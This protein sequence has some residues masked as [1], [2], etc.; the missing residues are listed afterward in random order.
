MVNKVRTLDFLPE[1]FKTDTNRQFLRG[2][3]DVLT[4]QPDLKRI[5]G[6]IGEKYG[7]SI[8]PQDRYI[9]EPTKVRRDYQL[10]PS[11]IFLKPETQTAQDFIDYPGMVQ[12]LKNQGALTKKHDRLWESQFY[13]WEPFV[14]LDK[15]VN[16]SQYYWIPN[17]P[18]AV[19]ISTAQ[20]YLTDDYLVTQNDNGY[21][22]E[23]VLGVNPTITLIRGGTYTFTVDGTNPFWI[24]G[25]PGLTGYAPGSNI[26]TRD[27]LGVTNNGA[28]V[29]TVTFTVPAQDAQQALYTLPGNNTVDLATS[30]TYAQVN[31]QPLSTLNN[32]DG[33]TSLSGKSLLFFDNGEPT[34]QITY[35]TI[36]ISGGLIALIPGATIPNN[37]KITVQSGDQY[38]GR[39]FYRDLTGAVNLVPYNS[40]ILDKL[41]YQS[42]ND[43]L[44]VGTINIVD[45]NASNTLDIDQIIGKQ[46][47]I[48]PNGITFTNGLKVIF[49]GN[50][51]PATYTNNEYYVEGVGTSINLLPV[52]EYLAVESTGEAIYNPYSLAP[53]D[54]TVYDIDLY[55]PVVPEYITI[56]RNS[57]DRN[58]WTR[59]N[60]WFHQ[61]VL[62][63]TTDALGYVTDSQGNTVTRALRPIV[64]F[65]GNLRLF[66]NGTQFAGFVDLVA[67]NSITDAFSQIA[68]QTFAS[69]P[70]VD[71]QQ[72]IDQTRI[73]FPYDTDP[74]VRGKIYQVNY[75]QIGASQVITLDPIA[76]IE[77]LELVVVINGTVNAGTTWWFTSIGNLWQRSQEKAQLNQPPLF[78]V[79]NSSG[80]SLGDNSVYP[81]TDFV[82][83]KLFSYTVGTGQNDPVLGF[84]IVYS[85]PSTLG[86]IQF[87]VNLNSDTFS[88]SSMSGTLTENVNTGFVHEYASRLDYVER[89]GWVPAIAN[90]F[91]YQVFEFPITQAVQ[92]TFVCDVPVKQDSAWSTIQVYYNDNVLDQTQFSHTTDLT[93]LTTSVTLNVP[94]YEKEKVTVLLISDY[95]SKTAYYEIPNNLENNPFNTNITSVTVGD[96]RNQ[97]R[98]I[99][100]NNP[101]CTGPL[102]GDNN[103]H[104]LGN[105]NRYGTAIIQ[106][107]A[108]L[109]LPAT[110]L[111]KPGLEFFNALQF[112]S[113]QYTLYKQLVIDLAGKGD[114]SVYQV[115]SEIL[116]NILYQITKV[117]DNSSAFFWSDML[118][119]GSPYVSNTYDFGAATNTA[120]FNLSDVWSPTMF[121]EANY[122]GV[123]VYVNSTQGNRKTYT[124]LIHGLDYTVSATNATVT[125]NYPIAQ[126]DTVTVDEYNQTY[127]SYCPN[128]P[129]KMGMY[130]AW[131]PA[132]VYDTSYTNPTYFIL[133]HDGSYNKLFGE[134]DP[135]TGLLNDFR[136]IALLEFEKRIFN[137]IKGDAPLTLQYDDVVPG[138]FRT[139]QYTWEEILQIYSINFLNWVG[140]NRIDFRQQFYNKTNKF[141]YNY[142]ETSDKLTNTALKQGYWRG[143]Y[144]WFY[145]T[146]APNTTPWQM[147]G[148][149]NEPDWW[150][151]RYGPAPYTGDNLFM[152]QDIARGYVWND[153]APY[154]NE[155]RVRP[156][157]LQVI[158]VD[159][160]GDLL[161]PFECVVSLYNSL[162]F[163]RNWVVG[164]GAPAEASYVKSSTWPF[165][166][167]RLLALTKPARFFN[168]FVDQDQYKFEPE[169]DQYLYQGRYHLD[170]RTLQV[171]GSGTAKNSYLNWIVDYVNQ[172]G[173][174]GH[175][176]VVSALT[177]LDVRLTYNLAGFSAKDYLRFLV[178]TATPNSRNTNLLIPDESYQVLLYDNVPEQQITYSS[179]IVQKTSNGWTVYGNSQNRQY[180]IVQNTY[181]TGYYRDLTVGD[182]TVQVNQEFRPD[183]TSV[184]P[185]GTLFYSVQAV[186]EFLLAYGKYL[187]TQ[188][189]KFNN[190]VN[191]TEYNW[192]RMAQEYIVWAQ[193]GWE[194][195]STIS[196]NPNSKVFTVDQPGLVVQPLTV[197]QENFILNQSFLPLGG[198]NISVVRDNTAFAVQI[199]TPGDTV[200]YT[201]L[202]LASIEHAI[203]FDNY[204]AFNDTI[205]N[206]VTG[207]RQQRLLLQGYKTAEWQG[208]VNTSGFILN[209][210]NIKEWVPNKKYPKGVIVTYK[211]FYWT[212][213][214]LIEPTAEFS[215]ESWIKTEYDQIKTGLLPNP[216]T[217]AY[218]S[219]Y[220]YDVN[221]ANLE[222]DADLLS[223]SLIGFR[224]RQYLADADL[225]DTTQVNVYRNIVKN[226]GTNRIAN[227]FQDAELVQGKIDYKIQEN[228]ALKNGD[229]GAVLNS[230]FVEFVLD[231]SQLKGNP[232]LIGFTT[233]GQTDANVQQ[234]VDIRDFTN[235]ERPVLTPVFLPP[236]AQGYT[237][238]SG[239]PTAGYVN[240]KDAKFAEFIFEDLNVNE[241]NIQTLYRNDIVWLANYQSRWEVFAPV[242]LGVSVVGVVNNFNN[243]LQ[244][245]FSG[246]H[247]LA[248]DDLIAL[249][250]VD[251]D[252][253][254][255]YRVLS[256]VDNF[257]I[258]IAGTLTLTQQVQTTSGVAF[259][260][261]SRRFEQA[262]DAA[263]NLLPYSAWST[264]KI[265]VDYD[266]DREWAVYASSPMFHQ[267]NVIDQLTDSQAGQSVAYTQTLGVLSLD[268]QGG[269]YRNALRQTVPGGSGNSQI[270][271]LNNIVFISDPAAGKIY[272]YVADTNGQFSSYANTLSIANTGQFAVSNDTNWLY[273]SNTSAGKISLFILNQG[274]YT[275]VQEISAPVAALGWGSSIATSTDGR[276]LFVGAPLEHSQG[277]YQA[278]AAYSYARYYQRFYCNGL[279]QTFALQTPATVALACVYVD[280]VLQTTGY[281]FN[282]TTVTFGTA[283]R[284]G[285]IVTVDTGNIQSVQRFQSDRLHQ[286]GLYGTSVDTNRYGGDAVV[287]C[288]YEVSTVNGTPGV[289]GAVYRYTNSGQMYGTVSGKLSAS[290]ASGSFF[291]DG[292]LVNFSGTVSNIV[293][294]INQQTP[295]NIQ[296]AVVPTVTDGFVISVTPETSDTRFN[297][298]DVTGTA[299][300]LQTLG[301]TVCTKTQVITSPDLAPDGHFGMRV[302][303]NERSGLLVSAPAG[304]RPSPAT[305][306]LTA[307]CVQD[308]TIFDHDATFFI[309][310]F[311]NTGLVYEF[312]YLPA[313]NESILN[314]G[315][316][317]FGQYIDSDIT[318]D[319]AP[320]AQFGTS[321]AW[322]NGVIVVGAPRYFADNRG[323]VA[324]YVTNVDNYCE[325]QQPTSWYVDKKPLPQVNIN[326]LKNICIY[327][328]VD[329]QTLEW[330][331]YIDPIQNKL[332]GAVTENLDIM[333]LTDPAGYGANEIS[334]TQDYVG[335]TWLDLNTI[336]LVDYHQPDIVYNANNW[337][338]AFPG[339]TAD[340][341]TWVE[342]DVDPTQ[343]P[344]PGFAVT[345][346]R[347][348]SVNSYDAST[349]SIRTKY[350]FWA[351]YY[352]QVPAGKSLSAVALSQYLLDPQ[353]TGIAYLAPITNNTVAL[354][355]SSQYIQSDYSSLHLGFQTQPGMDDKHTSWQLIRQGNPEDFLSGFYI[356]RD[357]ESQYLKFIESFTGYDQAGQK[358]P[359]PRLPEL[360]R[361]GT[362]FRPRQSMFIDRSQALQNYVTYANDVM[363]QYPIAQSRNLNFLQKSGPGYDTRN[364]WSY[365]NWW[366]P[367]YSDDT[368]PVLEVPNVGDLQTLVDEQLVVGTEGLTLLLEDGLVVKVTNN[369]LGNSEYYVYNSETGW[370]QIGITNGTIQISDSIWQNIYGWSSNIWDNQGW[371]NFPATEIYWIIRWL[372]EYCY[373]NDLEIHR[374]SS[375]ILMFEYIQTE[376]LQGQNYLPWLNKTSLIDVNHHVRDLLPYKKFQR[377]NQEFLA[378]YLNEI[379][380]YHVY[381]K[382]F[383]FS[384]SGQ[385]V[386]PGDVTD[387]D[388]P[389]QYD[390][391]SGSFQTPR[392]V[393]AETYQN[394]EYLPTDLIW[395]QPEYNQWFNNYGLS[396]RNQ[397]LSLR[398]VTTLTG[399]MTATS[400]SVQVQSAYG[401]PFT[402]VITIGDEILTYNSI[403][404]V[405]NTL[406]GILRGAD[407]T[408][409]AIH[410]PGAPVL[411]R[412]PAVTVLDQGRLYSEPPQIT[413]TIDLAIYPAPREIA[414]FR[415][416]MALDRLIG[417]EVVNPGSG[418]AVRPEIYITPSVSV[419]FTDSDV[420]NIDNT[421]YMADHVYQTGD[422]VKFSCVSPAVAPAGMRNGSYYYV[423]SI[424]ANNIALFLNY[425]ECVQ[426][427]E[428]SNQDGRIQLITTGSGSMNLDITA[429]AV[430]L[431]SG[432][433]VREFSINMRYD[434]VS[435]RSSIQDWE[436]GEFY[437]G[438][439]TSASV[440]SITD[441]ASSSE[442]SSLGGVELP[443]TAY[444][445]DE[446]GNVLV[447]VTYSNAAPGQ[448]D[449][450]KFTFYQDTGS[451]W[452]DPASFYVKVVS[453]D[454]LA[455]YHDA[456]LKFPVSLAQYPTASNVAY[457]P[458][459]FFFTRSLVMY[460]GKLWRCVV[461][462]NDSSFDIDKWILVRS[463]DSQLTA[464][465]RVLAFYKPTASMPGRDLRQLMLGTE[466]PDAT[467]RGAPFGQEQEPYGLI[468]WSTIGWDGD[469]DID[470]FLDTKLISPDFTY[471]PDTNPTYW[472]VQ[473]GAFAQGYG[474]E[475]L[476]PGLTTDNLAFQVTT[477]PGSNWASYPFSPYTFD[478]TGFDVHTLYATPD[479]V[480]YTI[481]FAD[482]VQNPVTL[483]IFAAT[484]SVGSNPTDQ[485][486]VPPTDSYYT[487]DWFNKVITIVNPYLKT[488]EL[489]IVLY[490]FGNGNQMV[491]GNAGAYA[492]RT[493][494]GH[495]EIYLPVKYADVT[496]PIQAN[497]YSTASV[498]I[499]GV[500][501]PY[502]DQVPGA[503]AYFTLEPQIN[504]VCARLVFN[505]AYD[506][507]TDYVTFVINGGPSGYSVPQTQIIIPGST[508]EIAPNTYALEYYI[509]DENIDHVIVERDGYRLYNIIPNATVAYKVPGVSGYSIPIPSVYIPTFNDAQLSVDLAGAGVPSVSYAVNYDPGTLSASGLDGEW[510]SLYGYLD[511]GVELDTQTLYVVFDPAFI[512]PVAA[513]TEIEIVYSVSSVSN[514]YTIS[515]NSGLGVWQIEFASSLPLGDTIA[516]TSFNKTDQQSLVT[517]VFNDA[518]VT[519]ITNVNLEDGYDM[520]DYDEVSYSGGLYILTT[521]NPH[522]L[523]DGDHITIDSLDGTVALNAYAK[524]INTTTFS[525]WADF[526]L[527]TPYSGTISYSGSGAFVW[528][529]E[530]FVLTQPNYTLTDTTRLWVTIDNKLGGPG[531]I[532]QSS[533]VLRLYNSIAVTSGTGTTT[534]RNVMGILRE[535]NIDN[536]TVALSMV[537]AETPG[538]LSFRIDIGKYQTSKVYRTNQYTRTWLTETTISTGRIDDVLHVADARRLV[539]VIE[540]VH[541]PDADDTFRVMVGSANKVTGLKIVDSAS[542]VITDYT[543]DAPVIAGTDQIFSNNQS[544]LITINESYTGSVTVTVAIGNLIYVQGE[545]VGFTSIDL[546]NNTVTGLQRA[547]QGT[548]T[549][550]VFDQYSTVQSV[551]AQDMMRPEWYD[552]TWYDQ[553]A[554][555]QLNTS[556]PALF[557]QQQV[558]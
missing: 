184:I 157:L 135:D 177:N 235:W 307:N 419:S 352:D 61:D 424:D 126:G 41:Y 506:P 274:T 388:L 150:V 26:N 115:P 146:D 356:G 554:P 403:N 395:Q 291:V 43:P 488:L 350:Y 145:D 420:N 129:S 57:R 113:E 480:T 85:N 497:Y 35:Y 212:S 408:T 189:V 102:Y 239:I 394:D 40:S 399:Y 310:Q 327:N 347:F 128:T 5:Q 508:P 414:T 478:H 16:Y 534:Y 538:E 52:D 97:Y 32:I 66:D 31:G 456:L 501:I 200:A 99:F 243:T 342:S 73:I 402:G 549:N 25:V 48:S 294:Q 485:I 242:S 448:I 453:E 75:V 265:W 524:V 36:T 540:E 552:S 171:Y 213:L 288:P 477:K 247:N 359:D 283:P 236:Y 553:N 530:S 3:L 548:I 324:K 149:A 513:G 525:L 438:I 58:A 63:T 119:S 225:S 116:D 427:V 279:T 117:R 386:Y 203:V 393:Y 174:N 437:A 179:V 67:D 153:G 28:T 318:D 95:A 449:G 316:Y 110:F 396:I 51:T 470:T 114:Y 68:G 248:Q 320:Q 374:N 299:A 518:I 223:Y 463:D 23:S 173:E 490:E 244:V 238:E 182:V 268:G 90:S 64:E 232:T 297:L 33:I 398:Q 520:V 484:G 12:A 91:Q 522:G 503:T 2:T 106:N 154:I 373:T 287:G 187:E 11:V 349:N 313:N 351:K 413:A 531:G 109:V 444:T 1:I 405:T 69:A 191:G 276:K 379:K 205:Y 445:A 521:L 443:V 519:E 487:V 363:I 147:L 162:T 425:Q 556:T 341:Y 502:R 132:V 56:S 233:G 204:T 392:L 423:K 121:T 471:D 343:Y 455:L 22:F 253:N 151:T 499:N 515:Y 30:L 180:F 328:R 152:W 372:N 261:V 214:R 216:S 125:I 231:Q 306:D 163:Q 472:D 489:T 60:R 319:V 429:R 199:L 234:S 230:N 208:Y 267:Q 275:L 266:T 273:V 378:G 13:S 369:N 229:F 277:V 450:Q 72:L 185:Y 155:K 382:D 19:P 418:Y 476:V 272:S 50:V 259:R 84:P 346:D 250:N 391:S 196:L 401:L 78:N 92:Q 131:R 458:E 332:L 329:N 45:S 138:E 158:P 286:G 467:F 446:D 434:R 303:M 281:T 44:S 473:G 144:R 108:S 557:L 551:L 481:S 38:A 311:A 314:P 6:F 188:G 127:G 421:I 77:D 366:A 159:G 337:G 89:T 219:L 544:L 136:D 308:D 375:L 558:P 7:Y 441:P 362:S 21:A 262:S 368:K 282:G 55:V 251:P 345:F 510:N 494:D 218:E 436:P 493:I 122:T 334:W 504:N 15:I 197:Q 71:G 500:R 385:D 293:A 415:P 523:S 240:R 124:Q 532:H 442:P 252:A 237:I 411:T 312:D 381:I 498:Y 495:S 529:T 186:S 468:P 24:Q 465:D 27:V 404:Y 209:E 406:E 172:R 198:S 496:V 412:L 87:T 166:L 226:K 417:I 120:T 195:G 168:V 325:T 246:F 335:T 492:L 39:I 245:R 435:Y 457:L 354:Y 10:D 371:D 74:V 118:P 59:S 545:F 483:A 290:T 47:Y 533:E 296:A 383:V 103:Y 505:T 148:L 206:L 53:W 227:A 8:E 321:L 164:D 175:D 207:L 516:V 528:K 170:P 407:G 460:G 447:T 169:F 224:P 355:N 410:Y 133:G 70:L 111:R 190:I 192:Q 256:V 269:F 451:S 176:A 315:Q 17:G 101:N 142:N 29:G 96:V 49:Q 260:F 422:C 377:D 107:S 376:S 517:D 430:C 4:S 143:I 338:R 550:A 298:L 511:I 42:G 370:V 547:Q 535:M 304:T 263:N 536:Q 474:P 284:D 317:A 104:N 409:P 54:T 384:Y 201:N 278:G 326:A 76:T 141:S 183:S 491:R 18:D 357:P 228:W 390:T 344:G 156:E 432:L 475:E 139:T 527:T 88:Y 365:V 301:I 62:N 34:S 507:A 130:P 555:L 194:V 217:N 280:D 526:G 210:D 140:T 249:A 255:F 193:Q 479:P 353:T 9:V 509:G 482:Q 98:S 211:G 112:N 292:F 461:S 400:S 221:R 440:S 123:L 105:V 222:Q 466:Y 433:P 428:N 134:Y 295:I 333:S 542:K 46:T 454:Q 331:D 336:K 160:A 543:I 387:F 93:K 300:T 202:N 539:D 389:A 181:Q 541:T 305:F 167:M 514:P 82:G 339:S 452:D 100:T 397:E 285:A 348:V 537:P 20:V 161:S 14:D 86:D 459:P 367:G 257:T 80:V 289:E 302:R 215:A 380:P 361:Y 431:T 439:Y 258:T 65:Q 241:L 469:L 462:N 330:L 220:Y 546:D 270:W 264:Q 358:V 360:V 137:N 165:D 178:E 426:D 323:L 271:A 81:S 416:I 464:A 322:A 37:Q 512:S 486:R 94:A 309:D 79:Y 254:G 364:F 340:V 83:S